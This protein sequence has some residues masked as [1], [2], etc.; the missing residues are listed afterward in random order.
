MILSKAKVFKIIL[1]FLITISFFLGYFL[2]E[3]A[4]G[5]GPEF[6]DLSWPIIQGFKTEWFYALCW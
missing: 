1:S 2:K 6:Y 5:G 3:N 4:A